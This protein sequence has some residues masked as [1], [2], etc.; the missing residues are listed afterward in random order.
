MKKTAFTLSEVLI[1]VGILGVVAALTIP[2]LM[3]NYSDTAM[4]TTLRKT[5]ND[6]ATAA[7]LLITEEGKTKLSQTSIFKDDDDLD[8][9]MKNKFKVVN[10]TSGFSSSNYRSISGRSK[11]FSCSGKTYILPSSAAICISNEREIKQLTQEVTP[12]GK[13]HDKEVLAGYKAPNLHIQ[14]DVNGKDKPN[15][16]GKDMFDFY[17]DNNGTAAATIEE[18]YLEGFNKKV[19]TCGTN[20]DGTPKDCTDCLDKPLGEG[21]YQLLQSKNWK[22]DY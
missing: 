5:I 13:V 20:S 19:E 6:F 18:T 16:G 17:I 2:V 15:M 4:V 9:F 22:M 3:Q 8:K 12:T 1:T 14:I 7:D 11:S 10:T 21:C